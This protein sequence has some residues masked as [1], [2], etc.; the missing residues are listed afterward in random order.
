M[1]SWGVVRGESK[2]ET[3]HTD[4]AVYDGNCVPKAPV[5]TAKSEFWISRLGYQVGHAV[6]SGRHDRF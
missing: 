6:R 2:E 4:D 1:A 3:E 5:Y